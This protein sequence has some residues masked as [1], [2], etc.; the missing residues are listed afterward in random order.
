MLH[1]LWERGCLPENEAK[2]YLAEVVLAVDY[3]HEVGTLLHS[4]PIQ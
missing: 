1:Y 3:L 2:Y 4:S